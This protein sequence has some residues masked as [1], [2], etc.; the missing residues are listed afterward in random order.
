M[1]VL[2]AINE[3]M[4]AARYLAENH[5]TVKK[6]TQEWYDKIIDHIKDMAN[7]PCSMTST[8]GYV[9]NYFDE[10]EEYVYAQVSVV[11]GMDHDTVFGEID[12]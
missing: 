4:G 3:V 9:I 7:E 12:A 8:A 10:C 11:A 2:Y 1:K 5:P 6:D